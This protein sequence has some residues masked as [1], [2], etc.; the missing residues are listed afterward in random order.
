MN[1]AADVDSERGEE[2]GANGGYV[3][4][5][6]RA[7]DFIYAQGGAVQEDRLIGFVFGTTTAPD[8]WKSLLPTVMAQ[9]Q[10]VQRRFDGSWAIEGASE[11]TGGFA[12]GDFVAVDVETTGLRHATNRIIEVGLVRYHDGQATERYASFCNPERRLPSYISKLTGLTNEDLQVAPRFDE[13]AE[14]VVDFIGESL[15][16]GHNVGFDIGF[17]NA[18]LSR[19]GRQTLI[20]ETIDVMALGMRLLPATKRPSLDRVA[21]A[22]GLRPRKLHRAVNDAE[23]AAESGLRLAAIAAE[24]GAKTLHDL[25]VLCAGTSKRP[26]DDVGRGR[27]FLDRSHLKQIPKCPGV[28]IMRD[29]FERVLYVGKAKNLRDRVSSYYSQPLGYTRKMD[30]L[31]ESIDRIDVETVGTELE[32][33]LLESQLIKRYQPRFNT[34]L[35]SFEHYPYIRLDIGNPWPR[36]MMTAARKDDGAL[37]FGP[38]KNRKSAK[39]AVDLL[40]DHFQLRTCTRSFRNARSFGSPCLRLDLRKCP[41]P[42]VGKASR[43]QYMANVRAALRYL[44]GDDAALLEQVQAELEAAASKLDYERARL[45]RRDM[46][47]LQT[48]AGHQRNISQMRS[49]PSILLALPGLDPS[50]V[51]L[52]L[53]V[54]G[55]IWGTYAAWRDNAPSDVATRLDR[56]WQRF[57]ETG[58]GQIDHL[59]IDESN[60][61]SR[62]LSRW[63][64]HQA[65]VELPAEGVPDW[66]GIVH[67]L[68]ALS[69][70][71]LQ[72]P[73]AAELDDMLVEPDDIPS[74]PGKRD[75]SEPPALPA[76]QAV[77]HSGLEGSGSVL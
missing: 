24:Q 33:L 54:H 66:I 39:I 9:A 25:R 16:L 40:N 35:R 3:T 7:R 65:I 26:K 69:H 4:L 18:E 74:E 13:I 63:W 10:G 19:A 11:V 30:G 46:Q 23:I 41:G 5:A 22:V 27:A 29:Q 38:F 34:A 1:R 58:V 48:I 2:A 62:W 53:V 57:L 17:L 42:C 47:T 6:A 15:L 60:I 28:Y 31:L 12:L 55:Q 14:A 76:F 72:T 8:L 21:A 43:D 61:L 77:A 32:A 49:R 56:A 68:L 64:G 37:Y 20:N 52:M 73:L 45:L 75:S 36:V 44:E 67:R 51:N 71:A 59:S 50:M 70:E